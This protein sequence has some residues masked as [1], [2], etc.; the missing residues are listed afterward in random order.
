MSARIVATA[1][2]LQPF[3]D[4]LG[5]DVTT[6]KAVLTS[7]GPGRYDAELNMDG[8]AKRQTARPPRR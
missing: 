8:K 6:V 7:W 2:N 4:L 5:V 3:S 1:P